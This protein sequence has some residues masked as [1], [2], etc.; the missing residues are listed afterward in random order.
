MAPTCIM[1]IH[2]GLTVVC[3]F[4]NLVYCWTKAAISLA[5]S[6]ICVEATVLVSSLLLG[7]DRNGTNMY[8]STTMMVQ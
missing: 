1:S 4:H 2:I 3:N 8:H 5:S 6:S 7:K